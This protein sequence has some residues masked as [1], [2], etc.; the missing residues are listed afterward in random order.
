[1]PCIR[2]FLLLF[3]L[4]WLVVL[5]ILVEETHD[6][7]HPSPSMV[8]A[9]DPKASS[10]LPKATTRSSRIALMGTCACD[11][12]NGRICDRGAE[13]PYFHKNSKI[14]PQKVLGF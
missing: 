13:P 10:M 11:D 14:D 12:K 7:T 4:I 6:A 5:V 2:L 8:S 3:H 9:R 1:M